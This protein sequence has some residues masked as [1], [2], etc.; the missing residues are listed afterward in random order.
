LV[1]EVDRSALDET[2]ALVVRTMEEAYPL[3]VPLV[4]EV[5]IGQ[6]WEQLA[7]LEIAAAT[8]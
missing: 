6:N 1:L 3:D 7:P 2:A 8:R 5:S 4:A